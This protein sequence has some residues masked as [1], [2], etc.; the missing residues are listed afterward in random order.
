[1][2]IV[3]NKPPTTWK[4]FLYGVPGVGKSRM[5]AAAEGATFIDL[6]EGTKRLGDIRKIDQPINSSEDL[7]EA[8]R[9]CWADEET[10]TVVLDSS[11][12]LNKLFEKE[13]LKE[14][15][16]P[17]LLH[18]YGSGY[19]P[20]KK[21]WNDLLEVCNS[22]MAKKN[23]IMIGHNETK[24][25]HDAILGADVKKDFPYIQKQAMGE[26]IAD[27]DGVFFYN[28][29]KLLDEKKNIAK[30]TSRRVL[31]TKGGDDLF[32]AKSRFNDLE[33]KVYFNDGDQEALNNFWKELK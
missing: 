9:E 12:A 1:M 18:N 31:I 8:M 32:K 15:K 6:E 30:A 2:A 24:T 7:K 33:A 29:E 23:I 22:L 28:F 21:K 14:M 26:V 25:E 19:G 5:A 4:V 20:M 27:F 11:T 13:V 10:K 17:S 16:I 3:K